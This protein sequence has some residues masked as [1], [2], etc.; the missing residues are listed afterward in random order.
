MVWLCDVSSLNSC[1]WVFGSQLS[2]GPPIVF[3]DYHHSWTSFSWLVWWY[4]LNN[5]QYYIFLHFLFDIILPLFGE[6]QLVCGMHMEPSP[7][8][9]GCDVALSPWPGVYLC[10]HWTWY[11]RTA[12][13]TIP[14]FFQCFISEGALEASL[15]WKVMLLVLVATGDPLTSFAPVKILR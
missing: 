11:L 13:G 12:A 14:L 8:S 3:G 1:C 15:A 7:L 9:S 4:L 10:L 2:P 6:Y 5:V